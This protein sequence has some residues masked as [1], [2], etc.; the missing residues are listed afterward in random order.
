MIYNSI[1]R[2][3][4]A[5]E[6]ERQKQNAFLY[7]VTIHMLA[8][9]V[10][11]LSRE[12]N[13]RGSMRL[14]RG[15]SSAN[16]QV[17]LGKDG[18]SGFAELGFMSTS[19][20]RDQALEYTDDENDTGFRTLLVIHLSEA[21]RAACIAKF[22]QYEAEDE[23][24]Y[25]PCSFLEKTGIVKVERTDKF[26]VNFV[27]VRVQPNLKTMTVEEL[28][29]HK[30]STHLATFD[31]AIGE[32]KRQLRDLA[33]S[34]DAEKRMQFDKTRAK[35]TVESFLS[36]IL[37]QCQHVRERHSHTSHEDFAN[38]RRYRAMVL[39]MIEVKAMAV[40]KLSEW[41]ENR[42]GSFIRFR[43]DTHLRTAHRR[44]IMYLQSQLVDKVGEEKRKL[45][46]GI[47]QLMNLVTES[48][49]EVNELG[50]TRLLQVAA[51]GK[52]IKTLQLL[53]DAGADVDASRPDGVTAT[54]LAAQFGHRST[55]VALVELKAS[56]NQAAHDGATPLYI[57]AQGGHIECIEKLIELKA[58][59][60]A[61]DK[62]GLGP[63]HQAAMNNHIDCVNMLVSSGADIHAVTKTGKTAMDLA[64]EQSHDGCAQ[65]IYEM[66]QRALP[67]RSKSPAAA[68]D[69]ERRGA[70]I[71]SSGDMSDVDGF[72]A[73]A[74]YA[75]TGA[76]VLFVMNYPAYIG[77]SEA[78]R[79]PFYAD[80]NPGLGYRYTA[81]EVLA[82]ESC[83]LI[84]D[85]SP[86]TAGHNTA[87]RRA[88]TDV[89][90]AVVSRV[91]KESSRGQGR[92]Y[93]CIGGVNSV[94]PF[95]EKIVRN[96]LMTFRELLT[97]PL[98][99]LDPRQGLV[100]GEDGLV[101]DL[102]LSAYRDVY[103][104]FV[105][106]MAFWNE[107]WLY[108]MQS[109]VQNIRG[110]FVMGGVRRRAPCHRRSKS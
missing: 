42:A 34:G 29:D 96:E 30:K 73:L 21:N 52:A 76:D 54:W 46:T 87:M 98:Q 28:R 4:P 6:Y 35:H 38:D 50:E 24:L 100:Y 40:S 90:F 77:V 110:V 109:V 70:L 97:A 14:Y 91:W 101:C 99:R 19:R 9:A 83:A 64:K 74:E 106:S 89:A 23:D 43:H 72:F 104:D 94:N 86:N 44:W 68:K 36:R 56:V 33:R 75:K 1:I 78:D 47:C 2:R 82:R 57:A 61:T 16:A 88:L 92:L 55:L 58:D 105:G 31:H 84:D 22:L 81:K 95:S 63:V 45:S 27:E 69:A 65:S 8:S 10:Q 5:E 20:K 18:R 17:F 11:K 66:Q 103:A 108:Q 41:L 79:D 48:I 39:E 7:K 80:R 107:N 51:D 85:Y 62:S 3:F 71:I 60:E 32:A 26:V 67:A 59:V 12:V 53:V 102:P 37:E 15:I 25:A 93:F 13:I 49:A